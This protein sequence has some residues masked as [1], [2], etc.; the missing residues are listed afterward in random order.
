MG[1]ARNLQQ[2]DRVIGF[3]GIGPGNIATIST[4]QS[5]EVSDNAEV[6]PAITGLVMVLGV[7]LMT[8]RHFRLHRRGRGWFVA[9]WAL[10]GVNLI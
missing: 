3:G 8:V 7:L 1:L 5:I 9:G 2:T 6:V 10:L 4:A